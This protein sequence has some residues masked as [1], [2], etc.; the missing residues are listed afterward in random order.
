MSRYLSAVSDDVVVEV[1]NIDGDYRETIDLTV[2]NF[3]T[4]CGSIVYRTDL[5]DEFHR[6]IDYTE[7]GFPILP[8][9]IGSGPGGSIVT[10]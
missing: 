10:I 9:T 2:V 8:R 3:C 5:H 1:H 4:D 6:R 7:L